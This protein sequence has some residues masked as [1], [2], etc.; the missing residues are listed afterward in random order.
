MA[1]NWKLQL[2]QALNPNEIVNDLAWLLVNIGVT[3]NPDEVT[4][5][6]A[7]NGFYSPSDSGVIFT[8]TRETSNVMATGGEIVIILEIEV[9]GKINRVFFTCRR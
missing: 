1:H 6:T 2:Q 5:Q 4:N 3:Q 7:T 9:A 8:L